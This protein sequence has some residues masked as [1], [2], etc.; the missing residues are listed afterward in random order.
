MKGRC[1]YSPRLRRQRWPPC[2]PPPATV[3]GGA[4]P[5]LITLRFDEGYPLGWP[6][7]RWRGGETDDGSNV[8][9]KLRDE[10]LNQGCVRRWVIIDGSLDLAGL[11]LLIYNQREGEGW[12]RSSTV[13]GPV[14]VDEL[15]RNLWTYAGG[16]RPGITAR[17][18]RQQPLWG[19]GT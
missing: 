5:N 16:R 7:P 1:T 19:G 8:G 4:F 11:P 17:G 9:C 14:P 3:L 12:H 6:K 2:P 18:C 10:R 13:G 15:Q